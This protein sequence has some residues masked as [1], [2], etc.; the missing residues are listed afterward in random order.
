MPRSVFD[1]Q[2]IDIPCPNCGAKAKKS[3]AWIRRH[4]EI[5]CAGCG[6]AITLKADELIRG[7]D[8]AQRALDRAM[9]QIGR[10]LGGTFKI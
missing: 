8:E 10:S 3:V 1:D 7:L 2:T 9:A 4:D 6:A 5:T